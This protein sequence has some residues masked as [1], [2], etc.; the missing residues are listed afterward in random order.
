MYGYRKLTRSLQK[1]YHLVINKKKV[2]RLC[3]EMGILLPQREK[4]VKHPRRLS[5]NHAVTGPNQL[6]QLDLKYGFITDSRRYFFVASAIDV[7]DRAIVGYYKGSTCTAESVTRM[8]QKAFLSRGIGS[9]G[10]T[11][12]IIRTDNGPQF[13]GHVFYEFC[14]QHREFVMHERIPPKSPNLNAYIESFH[15]I[16]ERECFQRH[17]FR[18]LNQAYQTVDEFIEFYN[19]RRIHGSLQDRSPKEFLSLFTA[20]QISHKKTITA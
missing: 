20:G 15:S 18:T 17:E 7:Y 4:K 2:Y 14:D 10:S 1:K 16:L 13:C 9:E 19:K 8:L 6:W 3:K 12:L 5:R 11:K